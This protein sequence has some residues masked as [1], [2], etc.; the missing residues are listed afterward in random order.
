[1]R[2]ARSFH[3][4]GAH[5][6]ANSH[7]GKCANLHGHTWKLT[8]SLEGEIDSSTGMVMDFS[9]LKPIVNNIVKMLDHRYLNDFIPNP[10]AENLVDWFAKKLIPKF[11]PK[12]V[13]DP[14]NNLYSLTI[15]LQEGEGGWAENT[16]GLFPAQEDSSG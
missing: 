2:V 7:E 6:L 9:I 1:M 12:D 11:E 3:F 8:V 10:T 4:D 14:L 16:Y 5:K 15:K 13:N